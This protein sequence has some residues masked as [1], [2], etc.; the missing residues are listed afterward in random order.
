MGEHIQNTELLH[1]VIVAYSNSTTEI[2]SGHGI[3][4]LFAEMGSSAQPPLG[5]F[6]FSTRLKTNRIVADHPVVRVVAQLPSASKGVA[7]LEQGVFKTW[8]KRCAVCYSGL[9]QKNN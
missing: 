9:A 4:L 1:L 6:Y 3:S 5:V 2:I 7:L 8:M